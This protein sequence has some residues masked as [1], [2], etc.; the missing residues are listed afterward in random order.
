MDHLINGFITFFAWKYLLGCFIGVFIGTIVGVLPGLGPA[1]TMALMLPFTLMYGPTFG[2]IMLSG[3]LCGAMY[4]GSTT[5]ILVNI[6]GE[7]ASVITCIDGYQMAQ[8]GRGGAALAIVAVG[9]FVAG[10]IAILG[11]QIFAPPLAMV[12]IAFGPPEY[13]ALMVFC[14]IILSNLSGDSPLKSSLMFALGLWLSIIGICPLTTAQRFT[15]GSNYLML[16]IEFLPVAVGAFG[17]SEIF[18]IASKPYVPP[19][20]KSVRLKELYPN[21]D[22]IRRSILPISRGSILGFFL[23]IVPGPSPVIATFISYAVEKRLS[24]TPEEFGRGAIEG[25]AA[26]EAANN[27]A[28]VSSLIPLLTLGIPFNPSAAVLLAGLL[29]HNVEPGPLLFQKSPE[30]FWTFIAALYIGNIMLLILNLPLVGFF[31]RLATLRPQVLMPFVCIICL[32][33]VYSVRNNLFDVCVMIFFGI[34]GFYFHKYNYPVAPLVIGIIL[35]PMTE[36]SFRKS[37]MM[38]EGELYGFLEKPIAVAFLSLA[39]AIIVFKISYRF[40]RRRQD[41]RG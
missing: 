4:G 30:L 37:L 5:S 36:N 28:A 35:G 10:T 20:L 27:S 33:G 21:K 17:I 41:Q 18:S 19:T 26:P 2:L 8:K 39:L 40:L 24:K 6:P 38:F 11:M 14:F 16:G 9:S 13:F 22:E 29:M 15:F 1:T 32:L 34:A 23:G 31:A 25:V 7:S 3:I 12:A